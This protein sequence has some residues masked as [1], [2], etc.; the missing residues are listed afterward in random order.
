VLSNVLIA[1]ATRISEMRS[2]AVKLAKAWQHLNWLGG[3]NVAV[4]LNG[5][6]CEGRCLSIDDDG[7]LVVATTEGARRFQSGSIRLT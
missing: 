6:L 4:D 7:T 2:S 5:Q 3:K 1:L